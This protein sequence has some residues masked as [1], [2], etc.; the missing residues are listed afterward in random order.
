MLLSSN[1]GKSVYVEVGSNALD[2]SQENH[3]I[4]KGNHLAQ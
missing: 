2:G 3:A 1:S 4:L